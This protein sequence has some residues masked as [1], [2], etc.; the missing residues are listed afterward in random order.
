MLKFNETYRSHP[1]MIRLLEEEVYTRRRGT[2][3]MSQYALADKIGVT[4]NCIYLMECHEHIPKVETV[5]DIIMA[6][7][8]SEEE[9]NAFAVKYM[10]AYYRD[11]EVQKQL[12]RELAGVT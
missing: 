6:L 2:R 11:K 3:G 4:R 12:E 10:V 1:N 7:G 8:F 5:F 9:R